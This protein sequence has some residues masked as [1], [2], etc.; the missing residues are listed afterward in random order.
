M[1]YQL[2]AVDIQRDV[3]IGSTSYSVVVDE[4]SVQKSGSFAAW[5]VSKIKTPRESTCQ[6]RKRLKAL[7]HATPIA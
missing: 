3:R 2:A 1:N 6:T 4:M 5:F 7:H